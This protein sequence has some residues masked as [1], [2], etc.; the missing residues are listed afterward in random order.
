MRCNSPFIFVGIVV[1]LVNSARADEFED[2]PV[3][4]VDGWSQ[5]QAPPERDSLLSLLLPED[6]TRTVR[7]FLVLRSWECEANRHARE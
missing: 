3:P 7:D 2:C 5:I 4:A 1:C 6:R